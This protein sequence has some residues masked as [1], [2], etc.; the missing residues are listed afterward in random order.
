MIIRLY[1]PPAGRWSDCS[2]AAIHSL[3]NGRRIKPPQHFNY[4][5]RSS[6]EMFCSNRVEETELLVLLNYSTSLIRMKLVRLPFQ[7][8]YYV[9]CHSNILCVCFLRLAE[10]SSKQ[11]RCMTHVHAGARAGDASTVQPVSVSSDLTEM[12]SSS[13]K[14]CDVTP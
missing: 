11:Q 7:R 13:S 1:G 3:I 8:N 6:S 4:P 9:F 2:R 10:T 5:L 12:T 14:S